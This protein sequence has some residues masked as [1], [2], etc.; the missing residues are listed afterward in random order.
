MPTRVNH[1]AAVL[2]LMIL[3]AIPAAAFGALFCT[4]GASTA[5]VDTGLTMPDELAGVEYCPL[6][7]LLDI[8]AHPAILSSA[9]WVPLDAL[10]ER[11]IS[12]ALPAYRVDL[13]R[14][15]KPPR[16]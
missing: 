14:P 16:P 7:Q 11:P 13:R 1:C 15:I 3:L 5:Y 4:P 2:L 6:L 12:Q 9:A 8:T 10:P